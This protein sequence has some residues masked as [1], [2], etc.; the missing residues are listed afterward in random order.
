MSWNNYRDRKIERGIERRETK[1]D[2]ETN[3]ERYREIKGPGKSIM[4]IDIQIQEI[5]RAVAEIDTHHKGVDNA[6]EKYF[7]TYLQ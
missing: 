7:P 5:E 2:R 1:R 6:E 4:K 3:V